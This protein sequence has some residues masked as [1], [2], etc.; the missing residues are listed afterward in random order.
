MMTNL[1]FL[2][3]RGVDPNWTEDRTGRTALLIAIERNS[4]DTM[5]LLI[6]RGAD[7]NKVNP[8][9]KTSPLIEACRKNFLAGVDILLENR[10]NAT[11]ANPVT[12]EFAL[13]ISSV[14]AN[15]DVIM[16]I[17][18]HPR[19]DIHQV[20]TVSGRDA[21][22]S[23]RHRNR[24][25]AVN[26]LTRIV[27]GR[28]SENRP[29]N[30][31]VQPSTVGIEIDGGVYYIKF[32]PTTSEESRKKVITSIKRTLKMLTQNDENVYELPSGFQFTDNDKIVIT[33]KDDKIRYCYADGD[34]IFDEKEY[35]DGLNRPPQIEYKEDIPHD[36]KCAICLNPFYDPHFNSCGSVYCR[37]CI[38]GVINAG[39][40]TD[41][42]TRKDITKVILPCDLIRRMMLEWAI[43]TK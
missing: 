17:A 16:K 25:H 5:R 23:A 20:N 11:Y 39:I 4:E 27:S 24:H 8:V 34:I 38:S 33:M 35:L 1:N 13:E 15:E 37:E 7:V 28:T 12:G 43:P 21:I 26:I 3:R 2:R 32:S 41:P 18:T 22:A 31:I 19:T 30:L 6:S 42:L 36:F 10:A 29:S 9:T 14:W 40:R